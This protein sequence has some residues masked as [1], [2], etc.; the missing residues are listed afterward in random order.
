MAEEKYLDLIIKNALGVISERNKELLN[1]WIKESPK[2][3]AIYNGF[4]TC[5]QLLGGVAE[6][7][8]AK[9]DAQIVIQRVLKAFNLDEPKGER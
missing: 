5:E 7:E 8:K 2:N 3:E 6:Y 9:E 4:K 1:N